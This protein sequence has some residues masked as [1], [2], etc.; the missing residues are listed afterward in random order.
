MGPIAELSRKKSNRFDNDGSLVYAISRVPPCTM[1]KI[2]DVA[3]E[4]GVSPST[5]SHVLSG[6]RPISQ[7][8]R[9]R[10]LAAIEK[11]K[12]VPN[13]NARAL[14]SRKS[15]IIGFFAS[16]ITETF[17]AEIARG[18]ESV[19][20]PQGYHTLIVSGA[21]FGGN[22]PEALEFLMRRDMD[23]VI[24]AYS[25]ATTHT[26]DILESL[27]VPALTINRDFGPSTPSILLNNYQGGRDAAE[28]LLSVGSRRL[29]FVSGPSNRLASSERLRGFSSYL[30]DRNVSFEVE[31]G[32]FT[33]EG[34]YEA[35]GRLLARVPEVDGV[36]GANDYVAA[37]IIQAA[38][39]A[40]R[41]VPQDIKVIGFDDRD[42]ASFWPTPITTFYY[43]LMEMGSQS[44]KMLLRLVRNEPL[45][46]PKVSVSAQLI[47]RGSSGVLKNPGS[48]T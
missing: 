22:I 17:S 25:V 35:A 34:G 2:T 30:A 36:F 7:E 14:K 5:V 23:G 40:G 12:Y 41:R 46:E 3:R 10:V 8:T 39:A 44:A 32:D 16:D 42:F 33:F 43:P 18:V 45:D 15:E 28:H 27:R 29:A 48:A 47:Q 11:L 26:T 6:N 9:A 19:L 20:R 31:Q 37:G 1:P 21:E 38:S 24:L 4:A 13:S